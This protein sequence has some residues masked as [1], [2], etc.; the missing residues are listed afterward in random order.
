MG[1]GGPICRI[2]RAPAH[3]RYLFSSASGDFSSAEA[4]FC[5][6]RNSLKTSITTA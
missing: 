6:P 4:F 1:L 5:L 2:D 3:A